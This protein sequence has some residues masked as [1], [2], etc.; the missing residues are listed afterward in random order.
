MA[1][2]AMFFFIAPLYSLFYALYHYTYKES[3][4]IFIIFTGLYGYSMVAESG[5]LDLAR[6]MNSLTSYATLPVT[7]IISVVRG[8]Y[9]NSED[10]SIDIYTNIIS[11]LVSRFT[12][13]GKWLMFVYG[14]I[15]GYV[16]VKAF[17]LFAINL[18]IKN[19]YSFL[20]IICFSVIF[21]MDQLAGVRF[22]TAAYLFFFGS[23]QF[24]KT[25]D[26]RFFIYIIL[27]TL[28]HFSYLI[29]ALL[30]GLHYFLKKYPVIIYTILILSFIIP[31]LIHGYISQF[32]EILGGG[33][34][35]RSEMYIG[36]EGVDVAY[37]SLTNWYVRLREIS[38]IYYAYIAL[39]ILNLKSS[40]ILINSFIKKVYL[41]S[42]L[43]LSLT[44]FTK[45]VPHLGYRLQFIFLMFAVYF[46]YI[47]YNENYKIRIVKYLAFFA[48]PMFL[49]QIAYSI[50]CILITSSPMLYFGN[51]LLVFLDNSN[52]SIWT[53]IFK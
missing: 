12:T 52:R 49:M 38:M 25:N 11:F 6:V 17:S 4:I 20:L 31:N 44:N 46:I 22:A 5:G 29:L 47:V 50:R 51:A 7:S 14:S 27:A 34:K 21:G 15:Y 8:I 1:E 40:K 13:N 53:L 24:L 18:R 3:R 28:V 32:S 39:V 45:D 33:I 23:V 42:L 9:S 26:K 36:Q 41:F 37:G 43:V 19:I 10:G 30:F 16:Y 48:L 2:I 35:Q